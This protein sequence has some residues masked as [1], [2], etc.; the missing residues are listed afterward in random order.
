L[1]PWPTWHLW[2]VKIEPLWK[3]GWK[4]FETGSGLP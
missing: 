1:V 4:K 2:R 3:P